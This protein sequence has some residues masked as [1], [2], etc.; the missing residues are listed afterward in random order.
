MYHMFRNVNNNMQVNLSLAIKC[1][2][3]L[4][5]TYFV[6]EVSYYTVQNSSSFLYAFLQ[7]LSSVI[8]Q[9]FAHLY[10]PAGTRR[11]NNAIRTLF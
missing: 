6:V 4:V 10:Y 7:K 8:N 2:Y 9:K 1:N 3:T 5:K 11:Q